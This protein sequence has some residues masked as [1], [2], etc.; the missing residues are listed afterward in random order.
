VI[1]VTSP[2]Q[3]EIDYAVGRKIVFGCL[4]A[5]RIKIDLWVSFLVPTEPEPHQEYQP[6][7]ELE[8]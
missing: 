7:V 3:L 5:V 4:L 2:S 1:F 8:G 6:Q